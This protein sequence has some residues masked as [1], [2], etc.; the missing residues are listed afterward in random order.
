ME[1]WYVITGVKACAG[2]TNPHTSSDDSTIATVYL[3][4]IQQIPA[5]TGEPLVVCV[6][7]EKSSG[8]LTPKDVR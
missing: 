7:Y 6:P 5:K 4:N 3:F 8:D 1:A 2:T